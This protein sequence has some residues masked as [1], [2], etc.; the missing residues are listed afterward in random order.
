MD[1]E[2]VSETERVD[3]IMAPVENADD[4]IKEVMALLGVTVEIVE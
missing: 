1:E 3:K 2:E 4:F